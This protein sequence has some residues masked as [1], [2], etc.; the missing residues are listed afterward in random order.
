MDKVK[1]SFTLNGRKNTFFRR[2]DLFGKPLI[3]T[4]VNS[5]RN[6]KESDVSNI[7]KKLINEY[8]KD[9]IKDVKPIK[10]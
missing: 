6:V 10:G 1:L 4:N 7:L 2:F 9:N 8:G 3:T 5:A